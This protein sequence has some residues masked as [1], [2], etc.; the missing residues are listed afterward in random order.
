MTDPD[1]RPDPTFDRLRSEPHRRYN[2]LLD[3]WILV[4]AGRTRRPW[5]GRREASPPES[6]PTYDP[7]CYLCPG[8]VRANGADL[9]L[10]VWKRFR[11]RGQP[12]WVFIRPDG[13]AKLFYRP[14]DA[15]VRAQFEMLAAANPKS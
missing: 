3:E 7:E 2:A 11:V 5:L 12:A 14:D 15:T 9:D 10:T 8:N 4:S 13:T 6:H 1:E